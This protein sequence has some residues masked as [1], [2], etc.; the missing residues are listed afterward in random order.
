[1]DKNGW[2][3]M[4]ILRYLA[5][6]HGLNGKSDA[7][8]LRVE[9]AEQQANDLRNALIPVCY[10]VAQHSELL[11]KRLETLPTDLQVIR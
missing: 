6:K 5:R 7:E 1:M 10:N 4:V 2:Q 9:L 3:S 11:A 8:Q